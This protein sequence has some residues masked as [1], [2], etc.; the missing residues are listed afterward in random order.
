VIETGTSGQ[1]GHRSEV[2][3]HRHSLGVRTTTTVMGSG[4][5]SKDTVSSPRRS[6]TS[7]TSRGEDPRIRKRNAEK[8]TI[9]A[10]QSTE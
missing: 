3:R 4:R 9:R 7:L 2:S 8:T 6:L 10:L 1:D 5:D